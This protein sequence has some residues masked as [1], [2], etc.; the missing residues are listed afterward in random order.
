MITSDNAQV[1]TSSAVVKG[2]TLLIA[3]DL[4][5]T[6][7]TASDLITY[8]TGG[9]NGANG[10]TANAVEGIES[11][12]TGD[13]QD[14]IFIAEIEGEGVL[15]FDWKVGSEENTEDPE[16]PYDTLYF[17]VNGE[18]QDFI[19]GEVEY[20]EVS[21]DLAAGT[22]VINWT[23]TKDLNT[24]AGDDKAYLRNLVFTETVAPVTPTPTPTTPI[25]SGGGGGS[26]G[27]M[28]LLLAGFLVRQARKK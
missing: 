4:A 19:S 16:D 13:L 25:S 7:G 8:Y 15:T 3:T 6:V 14:S 17:Y 18:L 1:P 20:T 26:L 11:G 24:L 2:L 27:W 12:T 28:T 23:Y 22:N 10:W 5:T 9:S 21:I